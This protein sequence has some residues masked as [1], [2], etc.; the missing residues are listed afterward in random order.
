MSKSFARLVVVWC[1]DASGSAT[2][3]SWQNLS[4]KQKQSVLSNRR[5]IPHHQAQQVAPVLVDRGIG[6][7]EHQP[8]PPYW[9]TGRGARGEGEGVIGGGEL[10]FKTECTNLETQAEP[11]Q[12]VAQGLLSCLQYPV[13]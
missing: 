11:Q 10:S 2:R 3:S 7:A 1:V 9:R 13:S 4:T 6:R 8:A 5:T 12:I